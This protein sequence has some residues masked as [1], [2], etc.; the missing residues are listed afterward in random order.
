M[1]K[2][3][4]VAGAG[5]SGRILPPMGLATVRVVNCG[6]TRMT[7]GGSD[8]VGT[9]ICRC[10]PVYRRLWKRSLSDAPYHVR[11]PHYLGAGGLPVKPMVPA[12]SFVEL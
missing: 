11:A 4:H 8:C 7:S 2:G 12:W 3:S 10:R 6:H 9:S 5:A 1:R